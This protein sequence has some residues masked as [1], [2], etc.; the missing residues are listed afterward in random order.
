MAHSFVLSGHAQERT[1]QVAIAIAE[2]VSAGEQCVTR[3]PEGLRFVVAQK[4]LGGLVPSKD[5]PFLVGR[6]RRIGC[7]GHECAGDTCP[8]GFPQLAPR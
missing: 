8:V 2:D 3:F 4:T 6:E 5:H 1:V 7:A